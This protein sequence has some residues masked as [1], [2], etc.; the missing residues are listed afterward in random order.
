VNAGAADTPTPRRRA[1]ASMVSPIPIRATRFKPVGAQ[2]QSATRRRNR[3]PGLI[4]RR[5]RVN[6]GTRSAAE[7]FS[8]LPLERGTASCA[9]TLRLW[10][11]RGICEQPLMLQRK[12]GLSMGG[13]VTGHGFIVARNGYPMRCH[14]RHF[15]GWWRIDAPDDR[16]RGRVS[17]RRPHHPTVGHARTGAAA[18]AVRRLCGNCRA[19]SW[20]RTAVW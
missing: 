7:D 15:V 3:S 1:H 16:H 20:R 12:R 19:A 4:N 11:P 10:R 8:G 6:V 9:T 14:Q 5:R 13:C 17:P 2:K 18:G